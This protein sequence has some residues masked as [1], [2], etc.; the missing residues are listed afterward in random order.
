MKDDNTR[1]D[2]WLLANYQNL[3]NALINKLIRTGQVRVDNKKVSNNYLLLKG[4]SVRVPLNF[5]NTFR[6]LKPIVKTIN[7]KKYKKEIDNII[8]SVIYKDDD[9]LILNKW[10]GLAVQGGTKVNFDLTLAYEY[11]KFEAE[12][13]PLGVHRIDRGTSG[14]LIL[15]RH[16]QAAKYMFELFKQKKIEKTYYCLVYPVDEGMKKE[17]IID[18]PL[19]KTIE[20][21]YIVKVDELGKPAI[22]QYKV[23][24][25]KNNVGFLEVKP[26]TGRTHQIRVHLS[27]VLGYP[28]VGDFKYGFKSAT[29]LN[30]N[31]RKL[32]LHAAK[33]DF[34]SPSNK[35]I[36]ISAELDQ[37]FKDAMVV[38]GFSL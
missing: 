5:V 15:A 8:K 37:E 29:E 20:D 4:D 33:I 11:L 19:L 27:E 36:N 10:S 26:I 22:T 23:I 35:R 12:E 3:N 31:F 32:Y 14:I 9:L 17:G 6:Y 34:I 28:I 25:I 13:I 38:L 18:A 2:R 24:D 21:E 30:I 7:I 16:K 1:L